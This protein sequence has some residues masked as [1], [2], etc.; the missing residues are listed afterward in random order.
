MTV[1]Y[2]TLAETISRRNA[3]ECIKELEALMAMMGGEV[4]NEPIGVTV[5]ADGPCDEWRDARNRA[6]ARNFCGPAV[7]TGLCVPPWQERCLA[8][9]SATGER[10]PSYTT[11]EILRRALEIEK[12]RHRSTRKA[13]HDANRRHDEIWLEMNKSKRGIHQH[14]AADIAEDIMRQIEAD[15]TINRDALIALARRWGAV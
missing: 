14:A 13:V 10:P 2:R 1:D 7:P 3:E 8:D 9:I 5:T 6:L 4:R 11:V 12:A 15:G